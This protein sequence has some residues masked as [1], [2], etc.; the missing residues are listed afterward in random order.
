MSVRIPTPINDPVREY[1]P[2]SAERASLK[3][4]LAN[5][6]REPIE[7]PLLIGGEEVR[8]GQVGCVTMPHRHQHRLATW[9]KAGA[10]EVERAIRA[11]LAARE[12][13]G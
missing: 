4:Q 7:I 9:H 2:G 1:A 13:W 11:A 5:F 3:C 12:E 6:S 8:T 10:A